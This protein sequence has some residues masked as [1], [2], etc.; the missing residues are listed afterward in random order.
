[1]LYGLLAAALLSGLGTWGMIKIAHRHDLLDHPN[2]RS[3]HQQPTPRGGGLAFVMVYLLGCGIFWQAGLLTAPVLGSALLA[4]VL[5]AGVGFMDDKRHIPARWRLLVHFIG[6]GV[7]LLGVGLPV[8]TDNLLLHTGLYLA[9]WVGG[10]WIIN[11]VNFMDGV[12]GLAAMELACVAVLLVT[13]PGVGL[14]TQVGWLALLL[15]AVLLG[16]LW[17]N[18]PPAAIFMGDVGSGFLGMVAVLLLLLAWHGGVQLLCAGVILLAVFFVDASVTLIRRLISG[19]AVYQ[20]HRLHAYQKLARHFNSHKKVTLL[21]LAINLCWLYPVA[22]L[23]AG[24]EMLPWQGLMVAYL[25]LIVAAV[26]LGAGR[27]DK[28][29]EC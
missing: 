27:Q 15:V 24:E 19:Q 7:V 29:S 9:V 20:A 2:H 21:A 4:F 5:V 12:D 8:I 1:M 11:L 26:M 3:S 18:F 10:V 25:P 28:E 22:R 17:F 23:V 13:C 14:D 6:V 16:F